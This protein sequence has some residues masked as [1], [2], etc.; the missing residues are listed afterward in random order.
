MLLCQINYYTRY[1][2]LR[3]YEHLFPSICPLL[4][5]PLHIGNMP[6]IY[7]DLFVGNLLQSRVCVLI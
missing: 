7:V 2:S 4:G 5:V 6:Y 1:S 3:L